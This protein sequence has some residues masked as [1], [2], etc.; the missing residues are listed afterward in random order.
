MNKYPN[1]VIK[2]IIKDR[3]TSEGGSSPYRK[4]TTALNNTISKENK[5]IDTTHTYDIETPQSETDHT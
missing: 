5:E 1:H 3:Q 2:T 4:D